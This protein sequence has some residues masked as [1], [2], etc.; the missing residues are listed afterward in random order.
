MLTH[1]DMLMAESEDNPSKWIKFVAILTTRRFA[2][3]LLMVLFIILPMV[4]ISMLGIPGAGLIVAGANAGLYGY[5][6]GRD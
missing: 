3:H 2:A 5:L 1:G 6:L 4:G